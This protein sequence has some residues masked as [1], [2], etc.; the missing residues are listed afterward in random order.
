MRKFVYSLRYK[1]EAY[2]MQMHMLLGV[3]CGVIIWHVFPGSSL[4]RLATIGVIG[5][6]LPDFDH[7]LFI[8]LYGRRTEYAKIIKAFLRKHKI[9]NTVKFIKSN[10]KYNTAIYSHNMLSVLMAF[11]LFYYLYNVKDNA[12]MSAFFLSWVIHYVFDIFEDVL[13]FK[14]PNPNWWLKFSKVIK[15]DLLELFDTEKSEVA[16]KKQ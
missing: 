3:L 14:K 5:G 6:I 7:L 1:T 2:H 16:P 10:H 11:M 4:L 8:F 15:K 13:F 9:R 12:S